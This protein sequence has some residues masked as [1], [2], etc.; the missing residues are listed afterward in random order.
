MPP[1]DRL[2][3]ITAQLQQ[4]RLERLRLLVNADY[5]RFRA[6]PGRCR[7]QPNGERVFALASLSRPFLTPGT[8]VIP[9]VQLHTTSYQFDAP[10]ANGASSASRTV[11]TFS[12]DSGMI[13]ER[14]ANF[15]GRAFRQTLEP[16]AF[17]VYTPYRDQSLLPNYDSAA[18]DFNFATIY[19]ENAFS[20]ND[21]ISDSNLLTLGVTTRLIDPETGAEAARFGDRAAP[22]L[23]GPARHAAGRHGGDRAAVSDVLFGAQINWTPQWSVDGTVQYNPEDQQVDP[24]GAS[25][26]RYNPGPYRNIIAAYRY[27]AN[28]TPTANDGNKSIDVELAVAAQRPVGRQGQGPRPGPRPGRRALVRRRAG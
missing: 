21:R 11:P 15:F 19:T 3:Q 20:G 24:H 7:S 12:L 8:F 13:F 6:R 16:R 23:Q 14:D 2:P 25:S 5:T 10:L 22:A 1:Y 17:Y 27:Q 26:A 9:K 28:T 4:V 18:N